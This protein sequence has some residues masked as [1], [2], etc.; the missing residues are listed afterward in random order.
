MATSLRKGNRNQDRGKQQKKLPSLRVVGEQLVDTSRFLEQNKYK[1][2][3][4][5]L[6]ST[7]TKVTPFDKDANK[8][9][10]HNSDN[11]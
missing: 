7:S 5:R 2:S 8:K 11:G 3:T 6:F 1:I 4:A 9:R 10:K